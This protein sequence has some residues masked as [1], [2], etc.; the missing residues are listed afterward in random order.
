MF[1]RI[2]NFAIDLPY[3]FRC[4]VCG[5]MFILCSLSV[6]APCFSETLDRIVAVINDE[7]ITLIDIKIVK[8]FGLFEDMTD[9]TGVTASQILERMIDQK[10]VIQLSPKNIAVDEDELDEYQEML[11]SRLGKDLATKAL[12]EFGLVWADLRAYIREK[13][14]HQKIIYQRFGQTVVV[15]LE[16][17]E[18]FYQRRYIPSQTEKG[19]EPQPMMEV[20][21]E[22]ESTIRKS[23]I[24]RQIQRWLMNLKKQADI[25]V[26]VIDLDKYMKQ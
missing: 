9:G 11:T 21:R 16:E 24:E 10:L 6:K 1:S 5:F 3:L 12:D 4:L 19:R 18:D 17:I 26:M 8:A 25:Q 2:Y 14:L 15:S 13:I 20:L 7:V 23:K 22:I